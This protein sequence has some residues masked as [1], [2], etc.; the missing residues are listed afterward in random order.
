[1]AI[2]APDVS[3]QPVTSARFSVD[4]TP[5]TFGGGPGNEEINQTVQHASSDINEVATFEKIRADQTVVDD[6]KSK[7]MAE[8]ERIMLDPQTGVLG[9]KGLDSV[10]AHEKGISDL[11]KSLNDISGT[12]HG[13]QQIGPFNKWAQ[14]L[15]GVANQTMMSHVDTQLSEHRKVTFENIKDQSAA[16]AALNAGNQDAVDFY[17][18]TANQAALNYARDSRMDPDQTKQTVQDANDKTQIGVIN[19]MLKYRSYEDAKN[20]LEA[21]RDNITPKAQEA[22]Q[23]TMAEGYLRHQALT[24]ANDATSKNPNS[25]ADAL[26]SLSSIKSPEVLEMAR[27]LTS[28]QYSQRR[29]AV[30]NDQDDSFIQ[31]MKM[32]SQKDITD[33]AQRRLAV[34]PAIFNKLTAEQQR[35]VEKGGTPDVSSISTWEKFMQAVKDKSIQS[36]SQAD[37]NSKFIP[38]LDAQDQKQVVDYWA[39]VKKGNGGGPKQKM[40]ESVSSM[41]QQSLIGVG[42]LSSQHPTKSQQI[43]NKQTLDSVN[44]DLDDIQASTGK[45]PK[46]DEIQ[47][48]IDS[49]TVNILAGENKSLSDRFNFNTYPYE[50]IPDVS[51]NQIMELARNNGFSA[52]RSNIEQAYKLHKQGKTDEEIVRALK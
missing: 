14:E 35:A 15:A 8:K 25:E 39:G 18:N 52:T 23:N 30:K 32:L 47:K 3:P 27:K 4:T 34:D 44:R 10:Q 21:N 17:R 45:P 7:A 43:I 12:L 1:M 5:T 9:S 50:N 33:S 26:D 29:Q 24:A 46:P 40:F 37:I 41:V 19:G 49:H 51:K 38:T 48:V 13:D 16:S 36:M 42:A 20:Y 28:E 11:Q 6:A 2:N 31:T 22:I